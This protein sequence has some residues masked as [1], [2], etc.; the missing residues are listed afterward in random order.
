[1]PVTVSSHIR[2]NNGSLRCVLVTRTTPIGNGGNFTKEAR[3]IYSLVLKMQNV[4]PFVVVARSHQKYK[5]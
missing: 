1:M 2:S 5:P 4:S 3:D